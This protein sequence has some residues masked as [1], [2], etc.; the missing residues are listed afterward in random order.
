MLLD[1]YK[2]LIEQLLPAYDSEDFN[3]LFQHLTNDLNGPTRL[4][5][6]MELNRLMAPC[7]Q[8]VDLRGKVNGE[9]RPYELH[10]MTHWLDDV[11]M[12]VYRRRIKAYGDQFRVGVYESLMTTR[13]NFRVMRQQQPEPQQAA[14]P[15][16]PPVEDAP[17]FSAELLR[18]GYHLNRSEQRIQISTP[19]VLS[20]PYSQEVNGI[21]ADISPSGAR[22]RVSSAFRYV[23]GQM[24]TAYFPELAKQLK[25][26]RLMQGMN[27]RVLGV[28]PHDNESF[29][30]L[31]LVLVAPNDAIKDAIEASRQQTA[32]RSR[33]NYE[34]KII[35]TRARG[36][37]H[38]FLKH[39]SSI[40][41][42]F[43]GTELKYCLLTEHNRHVWEHWHDERN[44]SVINHLL[45][46]ERIRTLGKEGM[47]QCSTLIYSF[48]HQHEGK[49]YFYSAALP[50]MRV[51]E[52]QLF[53][54]IGAA[55][56]SWRVIRLSL[57]P[58]SQDD[59]NQL[60]EIAPELLDTLSTLTHI[61]VLQDLTNRA[62][63]NDYRLTE[64]PALPS[65][66]L[67][68]F[69]H[70]RNPVAATRAVYFDPK[71]QR[72][73]S[74]FLFKTPV[75]LEVPATPEQEGSTLLGHTIDISTRG[76]NLRLD[77]PLRAKRGDQLKVTFDELLQMAKEAPLRRIPYQV[78]RLSP[79]CRN[80]QLTAGRGEDAARSEHFLRRLI[81]HNE[82]RLPV[83]EEIMPAGPLLL[84]MHQ[85]LLTRL[86]CLPYFCEKV[87]NQVK[88]RAIGANK[89]L[90]TL[91]KLLQQSG[92]EKQLS[93]A[94]IFQHRVKQLLSETMRPIAVTQPY[95]HELY[96]AILPQPGQTPRVISKLFS[97]FQTGE[98]RR[99]FTRQAREQGHFLAVRIT[100]VPLLDPTTALIAQ[101]LAELSRVA[102]HRARSL[103]IEFTSLMG[104]GEF[105]DITDEV[106]LR[107]GL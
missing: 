106:L 30:W 6:K 105:Y 7:R 94:P 45:S 58:I 12:N 46:E 25:D 78:V 54:H 20:L 1:E 66:Q 71:P 98:S 100:A 99:Q 42:F 83:S 31:R 59:R 28:T 77:E 79:D 26:E 40:P 57:Y 101:E 44:Q 37:E 89:P 16:A 11:A 88:V 48:T 43:A 68:V 72:S 47:S 56:D 92:D 63:Q 38:C 4:Q 32:N 53:W 36:Y 74:R 90:P 91:G 51:E 9:C 2:G 81:K 80:V 103:E 5:V 29:T 97:D 76:L 73:E 49:S 8:P 84:A 13:N 27:Y 107:L 39:T 23:E 64:K 3:D 87:E 60:Q 70:P 24:V 14:E 61:G 22:F 62:G 35:Q 10:G 69:R 21:S 52:R 93:L 82:A 50:E 67:Q 75:A 96:L 65:K 95:V 17:P 41:L 18:F 85:M 15:E 55:R 86:N 102:M 104:F 19:V 33:R 34:D